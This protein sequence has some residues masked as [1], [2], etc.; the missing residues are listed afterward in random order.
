MKQKTGNVTRNATS[1]ALNF[2]LI[3]KDDEFIAYEPTRRALPLGNFCYMLH[4]LMSFGLEV[5]WP[6]GC[7]CSMPHSQMVLE[8]KV[9]L[10]S[11]HYFCPL[12]HLMSLPKGLVSIFIQI[13]ITIVHGLTIHGNISIANDQV[14]GV[15]IPISDEPTIGSGVAINKGLII[16]ASATIGQTLIID[17][18]HTGQSLTVSA[19]T[20]ISQGLTVGN[21]AA[22]IFFQIY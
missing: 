19:G 18:V 10:L 8:P 22:I 13:N 15:S 17:G 16:R 9:Y 11:E 6:H 20:T 12:R 14:V 2:L 4:S 1:G 7:F 21:S 3:I 5:Y